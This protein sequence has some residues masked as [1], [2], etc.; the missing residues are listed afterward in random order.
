[1]R[2]RFLLTIMVVVSVLVLTPMGWTQGYEYDGPLVDAEGRKVMDWGGQAWG[3]APEPLPPVDPN[4]PFDARDFSGV[5]RMDR[6]STRMMTEWDAVPTRTARGEE[7]FQSRITGRAN[8]QKEAQPPALGNDPIMGCNPW[9]FPRL[10]FYTGGQMEMFHTPDRIIMLFQK[11]MLPRLIWMDGRALP[12]DPDPRWLGYSVGHWEGDTLVI[13]TTGFDD[14]AWLDQYGNVYSQDMHFEERWRRVGRDTLEVD[15]T[16]TDPAMY[17]TPWVSTTK[18]WSR[19]A[20][21][22]SEQMCAPVD[23]LFFNQTVRDPAGGIVRE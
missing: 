6:G 3:P 10:L 18:T 21:E 9:G 22:I 23:E 8:P 2:H 12:Q 5:W 1:M 14:R 4:E 17:E 11:M 20:I 15:Y 13:E 7:I 16:L 19:Q